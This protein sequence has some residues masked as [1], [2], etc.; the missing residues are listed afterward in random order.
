MALPLTRAQ[1]D[2]M[3][4]QCGKCGNDETLILKGRC[5]PAAG[6]LAEYS[7]KTGHLEIRCNECDK[8]IAE[9]RVARELITI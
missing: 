2:G 4:C 9:I 3:V 8:R 5:H 6:V 1:L 7:K